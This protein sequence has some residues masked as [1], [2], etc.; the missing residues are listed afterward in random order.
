[1]NISAITFTGRPSGMKPTANKTVQKMRE[2]GLPTN[3]Y[4]TPHTKKSLA[5]EIETYREFLKEEPDN[6]LFR[7]LME[8]AMSELKRIKSF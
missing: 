7:Q 5:K 3:R 8:N 1:M 2:M 6:Q 4:K